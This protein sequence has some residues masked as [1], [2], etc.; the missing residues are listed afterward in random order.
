MNLDGIEID[1]A[2]ESQRKEFIEQVSGHESE[3]LEMLVSNGLDDILL[4][5]I[6]I[7]NIS[8][9]ELIIKTENDIITFKKI[10]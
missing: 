3:I 10:K 6:D 8:K 2:D 1:C 7:E 5:S 4:N 9:T